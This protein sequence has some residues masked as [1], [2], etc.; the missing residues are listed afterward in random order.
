MSWSS[1]SEVWLSNSPMA[2]SRYA[3][4]IAGVRIAFSGL[5]DCSATGTGEYGPYIEYRVVASSLSV[6][7][8]CT[9]VKNETHTQTYKYMSCPTSSESSQ[10]SHA[11]SCKVEDYEFTYSYKSSNHADAWVLRSVVAKLQMYRAS[12]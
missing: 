5:F 3:H 12:K 9:P 10:S 7:L 11:L 4:I 1:A 6:H 2:I 8:E